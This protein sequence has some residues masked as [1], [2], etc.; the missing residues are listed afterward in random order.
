MLRTHGRH[1]AL[2]RRSRGKRAAPDRVVGR[3]STRDANVTKQAFLSKFGRMSTRAACAI[4]HDVRTARSRNFS[5]C[6][7]EDVRTTSKALL[8]CWRREREHHS[9]TGQSF[10]G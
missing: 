9:L 6:A 1:H 4:A 3:A 7:R 2:E 5:T 8:R 10:T